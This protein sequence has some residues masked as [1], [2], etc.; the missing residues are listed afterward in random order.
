MVDAT[1][2]IEE[3]RMVKSQAELALVR[4]T[5]TLADLSFDV[6]ADVIRPGITEREIVARI[7]SELISGGAETF[8]ISSRRSREISSPMRPRIGRSRRVTSSFLTRSSRPGGY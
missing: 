4:A 8:S 6:L 3:A 1:S 2:I 7:D 5:A